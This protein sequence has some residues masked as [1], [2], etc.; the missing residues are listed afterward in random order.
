VTVNLQLV[1]FPK[2]FSAISER[3]PDAVANTKIYNRQLL[4]Y[5][6]FNSLQFNDIMKKKN[7]EI[8]KE[9]TSL[10]AIKGRKMGSN[11]IKINNTIIN[12][13]N[14]ILPNADTALILLLYILVVWKITLR[15]IPFIK[16]I[17]N[18]FLRLHNFLYK[19]DYRSR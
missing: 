3:V 5:L 15:N 12:F 17:S 14:A 11:L 16:Y 7:E 10:T 18:F 2:K 1:S 13:R 19:S 4:I 8:H 9:F 6:S